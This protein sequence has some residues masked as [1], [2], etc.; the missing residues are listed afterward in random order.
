MTKFEFNKPA[1]V[2][3]AGMWEQYKLSNMIDP[4]KR[5]V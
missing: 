4:A 5:Y 1:S 2:F 3:T